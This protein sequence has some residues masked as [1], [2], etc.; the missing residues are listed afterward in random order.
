[1]NLPRFGGLLLC[2]HAIAGAALG[3]AREARLPADG[4]DP[5]LGRLMAA[6]E[7]WA[8]RTNSRRVIVD[9][10]CL[11]PDVPTFLE[12]IAAWDERRFWPVLIEDVPHTLRFL[13]AFRPA[14]VVRFPRKSSIPAEG[15]WDAAGSAV[16]RSWTNLDD[17]GS[18]KAPP[19]AIAAAPPPRAPGVVVVDPSSP[20]LAGAVALA[21]GRFQRLARFESPRRYG[22]TLDALAVREFV[23]GL[24]AAVASVAA[25]RGELGDDC[26]FITL[27]GDW[28]FRYDAP[29]GPRCL[30]DL[31][32][33][34]ADGKRW[35]YV[36]RLIHDEK[37][38]V[39]QAMCSL[40]LT[41]DSAVVFNGYPIS[42]QPW[43]EYGVDRAA[44][45]LRSRLEVEKRAG[46][47]AADLS[48]WHRTFDPT[49]RF[50]LVLI[51]SKGGP[52]NFDLPR[53]SARTL[54]VP[55]TGP[56]AVA[57]IHSFSAAEPLDR[58]TIAG[59]WI[60]NG[61]F[62]YF[63]STHEPYLQSFRT[64]TLV[65]DL[66]VRGLPFSAAVRV[67]ENEPFGEPWKL[68]LIGDPL[69]RVVP[70]ASAPP[71]TDELGVSSDW[72]VYRAGDRP[73][74]DAEPDARFAWCLRSAIDRTT[75]MGGTAP[76]GDLATELRSL[77]R[78]QISE[79]LRP[80]FDDLLA[81]LLYQ[82]NAYRELRTR[83]TQIPRDR[84]PASAT[85][86]VESS[87]VV[88]LARVSEA[89]FSDA[90][91]LWSETFRLD[92]PVSIRRY[93]TDALLDRAT[94]PTR[95]SDLRAA[96]RAV[97]GRIEGESAGIL[98]A[99]VERLEK[100]LQQNRPR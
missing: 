4:S 91:T 30:D 96:I 21:A 77:D 40:F 87:L 42:G 3:Q 66:L 65:A 7:V 43:A 54:D 73:S 22:Q 24:D 37:T 98:R 53:R 56:A 68:I 12:A 88:E 75:R 15:V 92:L 33:R 26:D 76:I 20:A 86:L 32:G 80:L 79:P 9:Q 25:R 63:G 39:Y 8:E 46:D 5:R 94:T 57:M 62:L 45:R 38:A 29:N 85:S 71:R 36:G 93:A 64:P 34:G 2:M 27:A 10:V 19:E 23:G 78:Q 90:L 47:D 51:N 61:A 35:A 50:G 17:P 1:M 81:D 89:K 13:R 74:A 44:D 82:A 95:K 67:A 28:P 60:A 97:G 41:T 99:T 14:R 6:A 84:R 72:P 59:R 31:I 55:Q 16:G 69:H 49:N 100:E 48:G 18:A 11:V 52:S 70:R 83:F 58:S